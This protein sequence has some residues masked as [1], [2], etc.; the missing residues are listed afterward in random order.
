MTVARLNYINIGLMLVAATAALLLPFETFVLAYVVLGPLHY[1]TEIA[2]LKERQFFT[3]GKRDYW[4]LVGCCLAVFGWFLLNKLQPSLLARYPNSGLLTGLPAI[5]NQGYAAGIFAAFA[6]ALAMVFSSNNIVKAASVLLGGLVG[7]FLMAATNVYVLFGMLLPS[8]VH[9]F[10]FTGVFLV[11]GA[12]RGSGKSG[13]LATLVFVACGAGLLLVNGGTLGYPANDTLFS[14]WLVSDFYPLNNILLSWFDAG[15]H[16]FN[17]V[18]RS[19][20]GLRVQR[21]IAFA[22]CY[23]YLNWFSKTGVNGW[24]KVSRPW[25]IGA[26]ILWMATLALWWWNAVYGFAALFL[27]SM[28]HVFL[29]FPLNHKSFVQLGQLLAGNR[30]RTES[31]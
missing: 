14:A 12:L 1:F 10:I 27:L 29:E 13:G 28:L 2:W 7:F 11:T 16:N 22:Y 18:F 20:A 21:F 6:G 8:L 26:G 31:A 19:D 23:H 3:T 5:T 9:V 15:T 17:D 25:L 30:N 4:W 24:H